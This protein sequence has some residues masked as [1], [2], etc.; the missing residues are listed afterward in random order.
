MMFGGVNDERIVLNESL[1]WSGSHQD[2]DRPDAYKILPEIR[3][4]LIEGKNA[5]AEAHRHANNTVAE[6]KL[7]SVASNI[8]ELVVSSPRVQ[9]SE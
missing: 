5:E 1:V 7:D 6:L 8:P 3:K 4:L 2:A 9:P